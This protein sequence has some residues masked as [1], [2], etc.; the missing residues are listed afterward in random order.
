MDKNQ[1]SIKVCVRKRPLNKQEID[2]LEQ[3]VI[4]TTDK[5]VIIRE[6][7]T[8]YQRE[9]YQEL[10][11]IRFDSVF[12]ELA[13]NERIFAEEVLPLSDLFFSGKQSN[14]FAYGQSGSGKSYSIYGSESNRGL[15]QLSAM[16]VFD[17][18]RSQR[19]QGL[20]VSYFEVYCGEVFDI[21][22]G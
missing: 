21:L 11:K 18:I 8:N 17:Q 19:D 10:H 9:V 5:E 3:D 15:A 7:K 2:S 12:S 4:E 20:L 6:Q 16:S 1:A 22:N 13:S 14:C